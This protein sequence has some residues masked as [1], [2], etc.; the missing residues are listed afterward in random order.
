MTTS[1]KPSDGK[2]SA[3]GV[4]EER[5]DNTFASFDLKRAPDMK[6]A[7]QRC[8]AVAKGEAWCAFLWGGPGNGKTHLAIAAI[9]AHQLQG[10]IGMFWKVPEFLAFHRKHLSEGFDMDE[11]VRSYQVGRAL[12]VFDDLG[13]ENPTDWANEQL[14]RILDGRYER[15]AP[16]IITSNAPMD[17]LDPRLRSRFREGFVICEGKDQR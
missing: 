17:K 12:I 7:F 14:Y 13:T 3:F 9:Q 16:T 5:R 10:K 15:R 6:A 11:I 1:P 4:I 8:F 2:R